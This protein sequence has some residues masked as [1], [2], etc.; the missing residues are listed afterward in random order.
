MKRSI[1]T[2]LSILMC[3]SVYAG[4]IMELS[5]GWSTISETNH[6]IRNWQGIAAIGIMT[7]CMVAIGKLSQRKQQF[8]PF[9]AKAMGFALYSGIF[10]SFFFFYAQYHDNFSSI[11]SKIIIF[12]GGR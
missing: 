2:I 8:R 4:W 12:L 10:M 11:A 7:A 9:L 3:Q 5:E 6:M 1:S